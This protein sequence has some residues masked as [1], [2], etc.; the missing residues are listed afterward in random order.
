MMPT[1][2]SGSLISATA[3]NVPSTLAAPHMSYFISSISAAG[4]SEMPPVSKV[5]PLPT[6]TT[7][8]CFLP[9]VILQHDQL[10][11]LAAAL[12]D[13]QQ[14]AHAEFFHVLLLQHLELESCGSWPV[15]APARR[16]R[17]GCRCCPAGCRGP[18]PGSCRRR[19]PVPG[20]WRLRRCASSLRRGTLSIMRCATGGALL[21]ACS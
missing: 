20:S 16:D 19:W 9:P 11:R 15:P 1:T 7:G 3:W 14:R 8:F 5:M 13:R 17:S 10:G 18:W 4:L 21:P 12:G 2:L 6:S